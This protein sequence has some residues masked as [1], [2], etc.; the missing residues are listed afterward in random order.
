MIAC[1]ESLFIFAMLGIEPRALG[2]LASALA[3]SYIPSMNPI[4]NTK[5]LPVQKFIASLLKLRKQVLLTDKSILERGAKLQE[6]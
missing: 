3:L 5:Y 6:K 2:M 1:P 4:F